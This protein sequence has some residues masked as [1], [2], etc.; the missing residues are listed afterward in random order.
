MLRI[1][2]PQCRLY[3]LSE[4]PPNGQYLNGSSTGSERNF[5]DEACHQTY[6][7][8]FLSKAYLMKDLGKPRCPEVNSTTLSFRNVDVKKTSKSGNEKC[9]SFF[10]ILPLIRLNSSLN[11]AF[12]RVY[13]A[14]MSPEP[15]SP[16][17]LSV[18][19]IVPLFFREF[20][21]MVQ[22]SKKKGE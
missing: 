13:F 20:R 2:G 8:V 3:K 10:R 21:Y 19:R 12:L 17:P 11:T 5:E 14:I 7:S 9:E 16:R 6:E 1:I 22:V 15:T 4:V 18:P